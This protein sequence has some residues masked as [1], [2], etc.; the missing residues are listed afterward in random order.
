[1]KLAHENSTNLKDQWNYLV[2]ELT[3]QFSEGDVLNLDG[4][5]YLIGVQELGQGKRLFKKDEKV[6]LMHVAICKL[7]E[8]YG[9]YEFD[10]FDKDGWPHYKILTD[11]PSLK[12]G[13]QTVLMKEA[14]V[15]YFEGLG[16]F[17]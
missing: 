2:K 1:M 15:N 5:I 8:P 17:K 11:L 14:I 12:P 9:Y 16:F 10:F 6:N 4:I 3:Q 13:E 7:L